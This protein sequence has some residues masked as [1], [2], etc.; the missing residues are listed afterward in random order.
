MPFFFVPCVESDKNHSTVFFS[1][2]NSCLFLFKKFFPP[3]FCCFFPFECVLVLLEKQSTTEVFFLL[4]YYFCILF[5]TDV[6]VTSIVPWKRKK[7]AFC[8]RLCIFFYLLKRGTT[9]A[10]KKRVI[11]V[12]ILCIVLSQKISIGSFYWSWWWYLDVL[13]DLFFFYKLTFYLTCFFSK[14]LL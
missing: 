8:I 4:F 7:K 6:E 1:S 3:A 11:S 14:S 5:W 13:N 12:N 9:N 10:S 2:P